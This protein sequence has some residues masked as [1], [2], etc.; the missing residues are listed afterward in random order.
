[1]GSTFDLATAGHADQQ[2]SRRR[3]SPSLS[4]ATSAAVTTVGWTS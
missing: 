4:P 2:R 3:Q 1:M